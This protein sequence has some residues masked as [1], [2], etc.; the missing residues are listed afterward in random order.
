MRWFYYKSL[1]DVQV[2]CLYD[3][4]ACDWYE[5]NAVSISIGVWQVVSE[6]GPI[7]TDSLPIIKDSNIFPYDFLVSETWPTMCFGFLDEV[8]ESAPY[9][10]LEKRLASDWI[11]V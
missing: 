5:V 1:I 7:N 8:L 3:G 11:K 6:V 9:R 2:T 4:V 10:G